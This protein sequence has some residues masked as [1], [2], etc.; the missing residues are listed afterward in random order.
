MS[1]VAIPKITVTR[2]I[3]VLNF[4]YA[5]VETIEPRNEKLLNFNLPVVNPAKTELPT[6]PY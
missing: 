4:E 1:E 2:I 6:I 5:K 3:L